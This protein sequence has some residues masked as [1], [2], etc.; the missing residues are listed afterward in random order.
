[1]LNEELSSGRNGGELKHQ[2]LHRADKPA[3]RY[4]NLTFSL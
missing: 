1:M 3:N 2:V 4:A